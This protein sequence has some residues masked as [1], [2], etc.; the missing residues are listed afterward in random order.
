MKGRRPEQAY[1]FI[2]KNSLFRFCVFQNKLIES[3]LV[4]EA[5]GYSIAI[6]FT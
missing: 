1:A 3:S 2:G 5:F 6:K 4:A